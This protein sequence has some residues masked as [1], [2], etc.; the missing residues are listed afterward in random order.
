MAAGKGTRMRSNTPK[1]MHPV[2]GKPM[3]LWPIDAARSAGFERI[4]VVLGP[5]D[6]AASIIPDDVQVA[7]QREARGTG[8]AVLCAKDAIGDAQTVLILSGDTPLVTPDFLSALSTAHTDSAAAMTLVTMQLDDP[9]GYGRVV[10]LPDGSIEKIV[11]SKA[12]GDATT[13]ELA[14][15]ETNGGIYAFDRELLFEALTQIK[16][17]NAQSEY[18]LPDVLE[19]LKAHNHPVLPFE[20]AEPQAALGV[21]S[22][23]DL[24]QVES[25]ANARLIERLQIGGTRFVDPSSCWVE[26]GVT[27]GPDS[28]ILPGTYLRGTTSIGAGCEVGPHTTL[29]DCEVSDKATVIQTY[30]V[31]AKIGPGATVGPFAYLRPNAEIGA[32]AKVGTFVEVKNSVIGDGAKVPHLSYIG[33]ADVGDGANIGAGNITANYDGRKKHRTKI[34]KDVRTGVDTAF[35][36]PV[37]VGDGA[38]TGAGSVITEDVPDGALGI[39]RQRQSNIEDYAKRDATDD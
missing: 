17:H 34:G 5:A 3:L 25:I 29:T 39:A 28:V 2:C 26:A 37:S 30:G 21:N 33:D 22:Q 24:A 14:I 9:A 19:I 27:T 4:V 8:D 20:L 32:G 16:P 12:G 7:I 23:V 11:E 36:A 10:R 13:A 35:V 31:E 18:Y 1:V 15:G 6:E 38:Y